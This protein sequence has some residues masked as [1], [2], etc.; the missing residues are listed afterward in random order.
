MSAHEILVL[1]F[2]WLLG[3][4]SATEEEAVLVPDFELVPVESGLLVKWFIDDYETQSVIYYQIEIQNGQWTRAIQ[5]TEN[6]SSVLID[7]LEP[8]HFYTVSVTT[9]IIWNQQMKVA[10]KCGTPLP[11]IPSKVR[12]LLVT[13]L[14]S[15][16]EQIVSWRRPTEVPPACHLHYDLIIRRAGGYEHHL[17]FDTH[18]QHLI[19]NLE[20]QTTYYF[21]IQANYGELRGEASDMVEQPTTAGEAPVSPYDLRFIPLEFSG[22]LTWRLPVKGMERIQKYNLIFE[23]AAYEI[24]NE[25]QTNFLVEDLAE[26]SWYCMQLAAVGSNHIESKKA[27]ACGT[28]LTT[29]VCPYQRTAKGLVVD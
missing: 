27:L 2:A 10:W 18:G 6:V 15:G 29:R 13:S 22:N 20:P 23:G 12:D 7:N 25:G 4:I 8:C 21:K 1:S 28:P 9:V 14:S 19:R 16:T 17:G 3:F 11:K 24:P 5:A 26:C